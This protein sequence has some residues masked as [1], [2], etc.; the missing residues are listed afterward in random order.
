MLILVAGVDLFL[1]SNSPEEFY[2]ESEY[3]AIHDDEVI[4]TIP[5]GIGAAIEAGEL[6]T[7]VHGDIILILGQH[8]RL[9]IRN[10]D[11]IAH[12]IGLFYIG[13]GETLS[14]R[15]TTPQV[16]ESRC[17]F[18]GGDIRLIVRVAS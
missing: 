12:T 3:M 2:S 14:Q 4:I 9:T 13:A 15:F 6:P 7:I 8:D 16:Y 1:Q 18:Q 10:E 5:H 11:E 17:S